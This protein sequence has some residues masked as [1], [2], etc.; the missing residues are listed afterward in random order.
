MALPQSVR[1]TGVVPRIMADRRGLDCPA[2]AAV[3]RR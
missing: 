1:T 3:D 2:V